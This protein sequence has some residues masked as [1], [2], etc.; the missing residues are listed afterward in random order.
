MREDFNK[1]N[2]LVA[3][4]KNILI[5]SHRSPD[6][7]ATGSALALKLALKKQGID[8]SVFIADYSAKEYKFLP[9]YNLINSELNNYDFDLV[10]ALDYGDVRRLAIDD[11]LV[12][13]PAVI[14]IDHHL[15]EGANPTGEVKIL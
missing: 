3:R 6:E 5:A 12:K 1:I 13:N 2:E 8:S 15:D 10:F 14:T 11:L 9:G 7:D 4:S